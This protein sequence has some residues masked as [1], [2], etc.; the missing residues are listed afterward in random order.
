MFKTVWI[1]GGSAGIGLEL[2]KLWLQNG[3][4]VVASSPHAE[5]ASTLLALKEVHKDRLALVNIDVTDPSSVKT[6]VKKAWHSFGSIDLWFYNAGVYEPMKISQWQ[7]SHFV[8]MNHV[9][10]LGAV[11]VMHAIYPYFEAK[12]E[13]RWTWNASM[14]SYFGLPYGAG[15]SAPKAALAHL[16]ESLQPELLEK[17]IQ[18]QIINHGFVKTRLTA[19][20]DF[21]MPQ[22]MTPQE[23]AVN[24]Y[25]NLQKPYKFEIRFPFGLGLFLRVLRLLPYSISLRL[26]K[27]MLR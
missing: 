10:Y 6:A 19:K 26:T 1:T 11:S 12:G 13:G 21:E 14:A 4:Q 8:Q 15:Y 25:T 23:A 18:M 22:L 27:R 3:I 7:F 20:N 5:S 24:I 16:A 2:V 17:N 9:N